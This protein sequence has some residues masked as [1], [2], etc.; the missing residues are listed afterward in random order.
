MLDI[1]SM[2]V[3]SKLFHRQ[4]QEAILEDGSSQTAVLISPEQ[5]IMMWEISGVR[6]VLDSISIETISRVL[7]Q[8]GL[9]RSNQTATL[10][11]LE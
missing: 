1:L 4:N 6:E 9:L 3:T 8:I 5:A 11:S 2:E 10:I 7:R